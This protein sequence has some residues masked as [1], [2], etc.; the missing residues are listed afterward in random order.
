MLMRLYSFQRDRMFDFAFFAS[1]RE[2][3]LSRTTGPR[4]Y[5][6]VLCK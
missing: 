2:K 3:N 5:I 1:L 6:R 4:P